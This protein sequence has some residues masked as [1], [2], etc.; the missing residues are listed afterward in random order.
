MTEPARTL[1]AVGDGSTAWLYD[2]SSNTYRKTDVKDF[3]GNE[4]PTLP[5]SVYIGPLSLSLSELTER[6]QERGI[7]V[8]RRDNE[9]ILGFDTTLVDYGPTWHGSG[10]GGETSG[11]IGSIWVDEK[12][13]FALRSVVDGGPGF[14]YV[15]ARVTKLERPPRAL[16]NLFRFEPPAGSREE[17]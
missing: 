6:W 14:E 8:D 10:S 16:V 13:Q 4:P 2:S 7:S 11:G 15:D 5:I 17:Q 12:N 9:R 3:P 1:I